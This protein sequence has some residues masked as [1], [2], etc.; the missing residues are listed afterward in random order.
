MKAVALRQRPSDLYSPQA[1][2]ITP[3]SPVNDVDPD[4]QVSLKQAQELPKSAKGIT[5]K[6]WNG[7][8]RYIQELEKRNRGYVNQSW[9][10]RGRAPARQVIFMAKW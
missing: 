9:V 7:S 5:G 10:R 1:T 3:L 2:N 8:H 6:G 4:S